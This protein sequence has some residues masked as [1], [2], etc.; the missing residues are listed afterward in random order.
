MWRQ[1]R[2]WSL[3]FVLFLCVFVFFFACNFPDSVHSPWSSTK[4]LSWEEMDMFQHNLNIAHFGNILAIFR[5][6]DRNMVKKYGAK[7]CRS[8]FEITG[9]IFGGGCL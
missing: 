3:V 2:S 7:Y 1:P 4:I 5:T 9:L 8:F 6:K